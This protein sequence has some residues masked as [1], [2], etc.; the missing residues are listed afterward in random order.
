MQTHVK[1]IPFSYAPIAWCMKTY[2]AGKKQAPAYGTFFRPQNIQVFVKAHKM[3]SF[4]DNQL[5]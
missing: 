1:T 4:V 3:L 2:T 5:V